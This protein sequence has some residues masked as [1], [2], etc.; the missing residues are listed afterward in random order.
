MSSI[1]L[2]GG[3]NPQIRCNDCSAWATLYQAS[4]APFYVCPKHAG[5]RH[6]RIESYDPPPVCAHCGDSAGVEWES[7]DTAYH[8][9]TI[10]DR[11]HSVWRQ[12]L[13]NLGFVY[14]NPDDEYKNCP[15][16]FCRDCANEHHAYWSEMW[17][18]YNASRG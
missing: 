15:L 16:A 7:A 1:R 9:P 8:V 14:L 10:Y 13:I 3:V 2:W 5:I 12:L 18:E 17:R 11:P 6:R 4:T